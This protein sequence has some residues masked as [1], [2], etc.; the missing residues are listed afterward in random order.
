[1]KEREQSI[2]EFDR[3]I[4]NP[5]VLEFRDS[6]I[7][8][9]DLVPERLKDETPVFF[10]PGWANTLETD[11]AVLNEMADHERRTVSLNHP[12]TGRKESFPEGGTEELRKA[13]NILD[14]IDKKEFKKVDAIAYSE[15]AINL[16]LAA[17]Y[18]PEK[19]RNI[20]YLA[21][22]GLIGKDNPLSLLWRFSKNLQRGETSVPAKA[23]VREKELNKVVLSEVN[24]YLLKNPVRGIKEG[25]EI[26]QNEI[27]ESME[28]LHEKGIGIGVMALVD[29]KSFPMER[30]QKMVNAGML[31]GFLSVRGGHAEVL[32]RPESYIPQAMEVL[33]RLQNKREQEGLT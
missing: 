27:Q 21:P 12:R 9:V 25:L 16:T 13:L 3:Q 29:D 23:T 2:S 10:A 18:E 4:S 28:Y 1:M 6:D 7:E 5:E 24:K 14:V 30:M 26:S 8:V 15:G 17:M 22:S 32:S 31:D 20:V 19:F 33:E 11:R